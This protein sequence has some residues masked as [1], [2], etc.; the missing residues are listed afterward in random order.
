MPNLVQDIETGAGAVA[1][2]P[3]VLLG[4]LTGALP[5]LAYPATYPERVSHLVLWSGDPPP[6]IRFETSNLCS[7]PGGN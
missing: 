4:W 7:G 6:L 2:R 5:A 1:P 3:F